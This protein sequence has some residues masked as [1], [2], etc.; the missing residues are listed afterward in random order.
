MGYVYPWKNQ[1]G[2]V[3]VGAKGAGISN[4]YVDRTK[5]RPSIDL[6]NNACVEA[7]FFSPASIATRQSGDSVFF[8]RLV[9]L[10]IPPCGHAAQ[11][12]QPQKIDVWSRCARKIAVQCFSSFVNQT[13][14]ICFQFPPLLFYPFDISTGL[15]FYF[16]FN[17]K[18]YCPCSHKH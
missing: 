1:R 16:L 3:R 7:E 4:G 18:I 6:S 5:Y 13:P 11:A 2:P 15:H 14:D 8:F 10:A 17:D 12:I 9:E